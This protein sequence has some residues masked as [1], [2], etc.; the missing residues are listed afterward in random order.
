MTLLQWMLMAFALWT[1]GVLVFPIGVYRWNLILRGK[2]GIHSF[3]ADTSE[4]PD[5]YRRA[6]RAHANCVE[7]LPVFGALVA[8]ASLTSTASTLLDVLACVVIAAR[9]GQTITH[10]GFRETAPSVSVRF[11]FFVAQLGSMVVMA[12]AIAVHARGAG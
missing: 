7:N 10:V 3:P 11:G 2:R 8:L 12:A 5:W 1:I 6:M 9:V 4:G